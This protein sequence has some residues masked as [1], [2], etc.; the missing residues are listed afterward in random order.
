MKMDK[1]TVA[2]KDAPALDTSDEM[3]K[4]IDEASLQNFSVTPSAF[5]SVDEESF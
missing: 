4:K 1:T 2:N 5:I 3:K